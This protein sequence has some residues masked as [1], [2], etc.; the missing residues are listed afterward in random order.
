MGVEAVIAGLVGGLILL[1]FGWLHG[2]I[3][4]LG[5]K[6]EQRLDRHEDRLNG[7]LHSVTRVEMSSTSTFISSI[8]RASSVGWGVFLSRP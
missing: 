6:L 2:D 8:K 3:K 1:A 7:I 4:N 5:G